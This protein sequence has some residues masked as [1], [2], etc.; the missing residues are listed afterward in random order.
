MAT[1]QVAKTL[2]LRC[3]NIE[4]LFIIVYHDLWLKQKLLCL[5]LIVIPAVDRRT[6]NVELQQW[7]LQLL[8]GMFRTVW[9][10]LVF[11]RHTWH[12]TETTEFG[13]DPS[14]PEVIGTSLTWTGNMGNTG[15]S[16]NAIWSKCGASAWRCLGCR[17]WPTRTTADVDMDV[18]FC[19][20]SAMLRKRW[21]SNKLPF[22]CM[23]IGKMTIIT[24][25]PEIL[26]TPMFRHDQLMGSQKQSNYE[27]KMK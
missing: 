22:S 27:R 13:T 9:D 20:K 7:M 19:K 12:T 2:K 15:W 10:V 14:Q 1:S 21:L 4:L 6:S 11:L 16:G 17:P 3:W 25:T 18:F 8:T 5:S 23:L 26:R 24:I